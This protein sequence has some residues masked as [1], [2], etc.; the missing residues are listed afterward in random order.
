MG[1]IGVSVGGTGVSVGGTG[2]L[3]G[4]TGVPVA[5]GTGVLVGTG[6]GV[7]VGQVPRIAQFIILSK[8]K[9][10]GPARTVLGAGIEITSF[11]ADK[12]D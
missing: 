12:K 4:G 6:V 7:E 3:V 10:K 2:V 8:W 5:S 9:S 1:E 11:S